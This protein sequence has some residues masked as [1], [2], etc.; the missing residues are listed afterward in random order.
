MPAINAIISKLSPEKVFTGKDVTPP[1]NTRYAKRKVA[2]AEQ[3]QTHCKSI[4]VQN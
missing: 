4:I 1:D 3:R 2:T